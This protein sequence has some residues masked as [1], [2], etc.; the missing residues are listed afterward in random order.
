MP[1]RTTETLKERVIVRLVTV[2][3]TVSTAVLSFKQI[4][5]D[6]PSRF[7][8]YAQSHSLIRVLVSAIQP[9]RL[10]MRIF[11]C[12]VCEIL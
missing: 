4:G 12:M 3:D 9:V 6:L 8:I 5:S 1:G 7:S 2:V 11:G 10:F